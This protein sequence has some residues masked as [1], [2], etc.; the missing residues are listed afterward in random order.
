MSGCELRELQAYGFTTLMIANAH[1]S[2]KLIPHF[3]GKL[4]SLY[5][6]KHDFEWLWTNPYLSHL[7]PLSTTHP[8][9]QFELGG[10]DE[11]FPA[12]AAGSYPVPP[13]TAFEIPDHGDLWARDWLRETLSDTPER[14]ELR[15]RVSGDALPYTFERTLV[16]EE[17]API[18]RFRY[19][20][21]NHSQ[22]PMPF[23]WCAHPL[24]RIEAGMH[25][26]LPPG[27]HV[28]VAHSLPPDLLPTGAIVAWPHI[29]M[30][31]QAHDLSAVPPLRSRWAAKLYA[32]MLSEGW[33]GLEQPSSGRRVRFDF[34]LAQASGAGLWLNYGGWMGRE[35][36]PLYNVGL[37]PCIGSADDLGE[38]VRRGEYGTLPG[39]GECAWELA[40]TLL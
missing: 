25:L 9:E 16:L 7:H 14:L 1:V 32:G 33:V 15:T 34:N 27:A 28:R 13:W 31:G 5:D 4:I 30:H 18:V 11:C 24:L 22:V 36:R 26:L 38:A 10:W 6:R 17:G 39:G 3:G 8:Q 40:V 37:E 2:V 20:L 29:Q 19:R 23:V 21:S 12:V 35:T